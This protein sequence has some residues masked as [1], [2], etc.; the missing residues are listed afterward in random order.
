MKHLN[1]RTHGH[2]DMTGQSGTEKQ[3]HLLVVDDNLELAQTYRELFEVHGYRVA[4][5][6]NGFLA[7]NYVLE[8]AVDAILCDLSMPQLDGDAFHVAVQ[9]V[10]PEL[11]TRFL[12]V[13]GNA[14]NPKYEEFFQKVNCPVL[15]KPVLMDKLLDAL[16]GLIN[17]A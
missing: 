9:K 15:Y 8:H 7:L 1:G 11:S 17:R 3:R 16:D 5:A 6:T 13:T 2:N 10:K 4:I 14:G 12:F